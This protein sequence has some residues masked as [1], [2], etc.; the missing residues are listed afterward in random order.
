MEHVTTLVVIVT[1]L[2]KKRLIMKIKTINK[3]F[4]RIEQNKMNYLKGGK[5]QDSGYTLSAL[6]CNDFSVD[7]TDFRS[8][9]NDFS[10]NCEPIFVGTCNNF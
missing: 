10:G 5:S 4:V 6:D 7:C 3:G 2:A 9:C 8:D 1:L